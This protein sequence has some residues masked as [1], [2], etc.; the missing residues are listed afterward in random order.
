[1]TT[2]MMEDPRIDPRIKAV[3]GFLSPGPAR[4][5]PSREAMLAGMAQAAAAPAKP[6]MMTV[7]AQA[8]YE[9]VSPL[10]GVESRTQTIDS[11]PDGNAIKLQIITPEGQGPWP[12]VYYIHGGGMMVGSCYDPPYPAWGRMIAR[13]GAVVVMIDFRNCML[14]S[15]TPDIGPFPAGLNDCISALRWVRD[16]TAALGVDPARIVVSGESGGANLAVATAMS[17]KRSGELSAVKGL[18]L[19]CPYTAGEWP[20]KPGSAALENAGILVDM[21]SN[22]GAMAYGIEAFDRR[23]PLAWPGF[24]TEE[25]FAGLPPTIIHVNE[26]DGLR[27]DGVKLFRTMLRAGVSV[28]CR[29]LMGTTHG[30]EA[31]VILCPEISR[32][33]ARDIVALAG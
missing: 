28:R 10:S 26:C 9:K 3:F 15:S 4:N 11:A 6:S 16:N 1:M 20:G 30:T 13:N 19:M 22:A 21:R 12:C 18:F 17:L 8:D 33:T 7:L 29:Q 31:F 25:D 14:P 27:D 23:D 24:A 32:E 2:P 5:V